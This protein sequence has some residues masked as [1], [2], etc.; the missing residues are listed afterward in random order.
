MSSL[1]RDAV[2]E[3]K[4][5]AYFD[6]TQQHRQQ[7]Q[8]Q[9]Q[10]YQQ[11]QQQQQYSYHQQQEPTHAS[12]TMNKYPQPLVATT[13]SSSS[14]IGGGGLGLQHNQQILPS[15]AGRGGQEGWGPFGAKTNLG[16]G[17]DPARLRQGSPT[18][19]HRA[20]WLQRMDA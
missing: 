17:G 10:P 16:G 11:Q 5:Q 9:H 15:R 1:R 13:R 20:A 12:N 19:G 18:T 7:Q 3:Q 6:R 14:N 8:Q 4:K 2:W